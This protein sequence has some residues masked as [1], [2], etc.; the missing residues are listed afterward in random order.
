MYQLATGRIAG[1]LGQLLPELQG[2]GWARLQGL[3]G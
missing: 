2:A 1:L 3:A